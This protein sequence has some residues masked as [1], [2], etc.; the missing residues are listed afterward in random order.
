MQ[1]VRLRIAQHTQD[2]V[3]KHV[4]LRQAFFRGAK[5]RKVARSDHQTCIRALDVD[6]RTIKLFPDRGLATQALDE[7]FA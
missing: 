7:Q 1:C 3:H 6:V 4:R 5:A 2:T